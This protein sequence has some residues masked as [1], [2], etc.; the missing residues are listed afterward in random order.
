[1]DLVVLQVIIQKQIK[2]DLVFSSSSAAEHVNSST[3]QNLSS[4]FLK[5]FYKNS[6]RHFYQD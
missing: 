3:V 5:E 6:K 2:E 1:M 4:L